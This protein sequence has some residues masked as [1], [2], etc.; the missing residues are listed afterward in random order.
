LTN[1]S[2]EADSEEQAI[3]LATGCWRGD[4]DAVGHETYLGNEFADIYKVYVDK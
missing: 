1:Y 2:V 3:E 4:D